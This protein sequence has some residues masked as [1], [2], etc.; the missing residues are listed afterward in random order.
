MQGKYNNIDNFFSNL[1]Y[2]RQRDY[3][4]RALRVAKEVNAGED[5]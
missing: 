1:D 3:V 5:I 2:I 4:M